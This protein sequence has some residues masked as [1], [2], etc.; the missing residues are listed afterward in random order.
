MHLARELQQGHRLAT[1]RNDTAIL[2]NVIRC[3][4][5]LFD[6]RALRERAARRRVGGAVLIV[7]IT[8]VANDVG[9]GGPTKTRAANCPALHV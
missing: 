4:A 8:D 3:R 6:P 2:A 5:R 9:P 7:A 1:D